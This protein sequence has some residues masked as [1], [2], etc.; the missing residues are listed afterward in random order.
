M[1]GF[2]I[3]RPARLTATLGTGVLTVWIIAAALDSL[4]VTDFK[5]SDAAVPL[6]D[7]GEAPVSVETDDADTGTSVAANKARIQLP[8]A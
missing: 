5:N 7:G 2:S 1:M 4:G 3:R 8:S 6:E